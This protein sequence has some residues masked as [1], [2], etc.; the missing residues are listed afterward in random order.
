M[1]HT[2]NNRPCEDQARKFLLPPGEETEAFDEIIA[3]H[4]AIFQVINNSELDDTTKNT[5]YRLEK[6]LNHYVWLLS[7]RRLQLK[8]KSE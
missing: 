7:D 2:Q 6:H 8:A 4:E 1:P 3:T 5:L